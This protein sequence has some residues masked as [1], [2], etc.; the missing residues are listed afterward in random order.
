MTRH[1]FFLIRVRVYFIYC[2][3]PC[4]S[5]RSGSVAQATVRVLADVKRFT[6]AVAE[7]DRAWS[8]SFQRDVREVVSSIAG[9][10]EG[11]EVVKGCNA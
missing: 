8:K 4:L 1:N 6:A 10:V 3:T 5:S 7:R 9:G 11:R 2:G